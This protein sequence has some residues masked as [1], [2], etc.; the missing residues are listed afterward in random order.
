VATNRALRKALLK[1]RRFTSQR[2]SQLVQRRKAELPMSTE[3]ATYTIAHE[4][5]IDVSKFLTPDE[6]ARVATLVSQL[7]TVQPA[8]RATNGR[9]TRS[10]P[11]APKQAVVTIG[12]LNIEKLPGMSA[13]HAAEAKRM[14][15]V[16][17]A[18][19]VFENSL[20]D[21]I[22]RVLRKQHGDDWW[23][24]GVSQGIQDIHTERKAKEKDDPWHGARGARPI[25]YVDL[26]HLAKI[27]KQN[28]SLFEKIFPSQVWIES[29]IRHNMNVSRR[30][31]AHMNPLSDD[32][33]KNVEHALRN[34]AKVLKA[35]AVEIP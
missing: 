12:G 5:G 3:D 24:N 19:Y 6:T 8:A 15:N 23:A 20:R 2:L 31:V 11:A 17:A 28:W 1:K 32:D 9:A 7:K 16:N 4:S 14:S 33:V 13:K 26:E 30:P 25:D 10:R 29:L 35:N 27:I 34:Y 18:M 21:I 22:E